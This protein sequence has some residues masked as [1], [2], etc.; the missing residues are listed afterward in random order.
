LS[1]HQRG[2]I[3][4]LTEAGLLRRFG[5]C[6]RGFVVV[7]RLTNEEILL[8]FHVTDKTKTNQELNV[9]TEEGITLVYHK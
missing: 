2:I 7:D 9:L 1:F 8:K 4:C 3:D 5:E 6:W